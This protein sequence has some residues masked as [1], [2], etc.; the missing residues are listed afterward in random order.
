M[1][2][3]REKECDFPAGRRLARILFLCLALFLGAFPGGP[4]SAAADGS[5]HD[6]APRAIA[7]IAAPIVTAGECHATGSCFVVVLPARQSLSEGVH[8]RGRRAPPP[9]QALPAGAEIQPQSPPPRR[10]T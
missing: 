10:S 3:A 1:G 4:S 2:S 7:S 6:H 8:P 9:A 5:D